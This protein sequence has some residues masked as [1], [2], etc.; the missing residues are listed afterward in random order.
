MIGSKVMKWWNANWWNLPKDDIS[1]VEHTTNMRLTITYGACIGRMFK[2]TYC[3][4]L[5]GGRYVIDGAPLSSFTKNSA[6]IS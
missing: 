2:Y 5:S 6:I 3:M 1:N 4:V